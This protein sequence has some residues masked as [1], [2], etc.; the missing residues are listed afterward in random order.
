MRAILQHFD[1]S[2]K[3]ETRRSVS[4]NYIILIQNL[5]YLT[6]LFSVF[7]KTLVQPA[8]NT[9]ARR[10]LESINDQENVDTVI[11]TEQKETPAAGSE[12]TGES[13][14]I[15]KDSGKRKLESCSDVLEKPAKKTKPDKK[16][17]AAKKKTIPL[18]KGQ[19]QLTAF[20][21][22]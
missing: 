4:L 1:T 14:A 19:K 11:A 10:V 17:K 9:S 21:R 12:K 6:G 22:V 7:S 15:R 13:N 3:C 20:F 5:E 2:F 8:K 16:P 18:Q